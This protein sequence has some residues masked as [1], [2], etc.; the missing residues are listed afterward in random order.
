MANL[1]AFADMII[2]EDYHNDLINS[3]IA[4]IQ[5]SMSCIGIKAI[6]RLYDRGFRNSQL[7]KYGMQTIYFNMVSNPKAWREG[8]DEIGVKT[9]STNAEIMF[10][11]QKEIWRALIEKPKMNPS[12]LGGSVFHEHKDG[13]KCFSKKRKRGSDD[14]EE[15]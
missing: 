5:M 15:V 13:K 1:Y 2:C 12:A 11:F 10:D 7:A 4:R 14:F 8:K 6:M 3:I 9:W